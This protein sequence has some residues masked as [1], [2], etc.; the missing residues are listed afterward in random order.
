MN[1]VRTWNGMLGIS[2]LMASSLSQGH[3]WRKRMD[4]SKVAPPQFSRLYRLEKL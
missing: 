2:F 4:T 3:S 1:R